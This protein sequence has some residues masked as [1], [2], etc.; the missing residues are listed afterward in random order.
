MKKRCIS[1]LIAILP[2]G[3]VCHAQPVSDSLEF[4]PQHVG[5]FSGAMK[6][7]SYRNKNSSYLEA[8]QVTINMMNRMTPIARN[9]S[10]G[11]YQYV[12]RTKTFNGKSL[13]TAQCERLIASDWQSYVSEPLDSVQN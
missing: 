13:T 6:S 8:H 5:S 11:A 10:M 3:F 2:M 4:D 9:Q 12:L 7:C 1:L